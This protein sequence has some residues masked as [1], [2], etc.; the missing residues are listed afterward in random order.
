MLKFIET[1]RKKSEL[2][3]LKLQY[4][5]ECDYLACCQFTLKKSIA[6]EHHN[7]SKA[8]REIITESTTECNRL[9]AKMALIY[10]WLRVARENNKT[11]TT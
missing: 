4:R 3:R 8:L 11:M 7:L 10:E 9:K 1:Y 6:K 5:Y 2:R